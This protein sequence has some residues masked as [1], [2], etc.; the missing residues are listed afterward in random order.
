M[1]MATQPPG[2][3]TGS[4]A[5]PPIVAS[6][7]ATPAADDPAA[8]ARQVLAA[9]GFSTGS[10]Y[11]VEVLFKEVATDGEGPYLTFQSRGYIPNSMRRTLEK[12]IDSMRQPGKLRAGYGLTPGANGFLIQKTAY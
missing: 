8:K 3:P 1:S 10:G 2:I 5:F 12:A 7:S 9:A 6:A 11:E 4:S